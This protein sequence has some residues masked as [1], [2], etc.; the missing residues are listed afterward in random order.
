MNKVL[1]ILIVI[2]VLEM[3]AKGLETKLKEF[4]I[5]GKRKYRIQHCQEEPEFWEESWRPNKSGCHSVQ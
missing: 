3:I 5:R 2:G 1:V 4:K